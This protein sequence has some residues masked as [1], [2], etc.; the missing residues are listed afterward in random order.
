M[1]KISISRRGLVDVDSLVWENSGGIW[2]SGDFSVNGSNETGEG[3]F[4]KVI[5]LTTESF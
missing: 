3:L 1:F 2:T 4:W 5:K